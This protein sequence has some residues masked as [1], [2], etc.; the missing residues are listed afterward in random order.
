VLRATHAQWEGRG[1]G[2]SGWLLVVG[3][4][5][6]A[7]WTGVHR[8]DVRWFGI[9]LFDSTYIFVA[10]VAIGSLLVGLAFRRTRNRRRFLR[11]TVCFVASAA[12]SF[13]GGIGDRFGGFWA[14]PDGWIQ[15]HAVW[16]VGGAL[17]LLAA[18]EA[19]A[20][21]GDDRSLLP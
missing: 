9:K 5:L 3:V 17:A 20:T 2:W 6:A 8:N 18:Y 15:G 4:W 10:A 1:K 14:S 19:L 21:C 11:A 13:S 12:V 7:T 16:H